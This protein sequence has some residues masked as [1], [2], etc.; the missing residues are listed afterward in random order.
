[1]AAGFDLT[2]G[3]PRP[4][5]EHVLCAFMPCSGL[6]FGW[7]ALDHSRQQWGQRK[8]SGGPARALPGSQLQAKGLSTLCSLWEWQEALKGKLLLYHHVQTLWA[9]IK[10]M[11]PAGM[12]RTNPAY[13]QACK[14]CIQ[15]PSPPKIICTCILSYWEMHPPLPHTQFKGRKEKGLKALLSF[16]L[17]RRVIRFFRHWNGLWPCH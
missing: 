3:A 11:Y 15:S 17:I 7:A 4:Q 1:M 10:H 12:T 16:M 5:G 14:V 6:C 9:Q 8:A 2:L 13:K